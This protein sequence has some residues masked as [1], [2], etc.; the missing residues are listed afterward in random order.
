MFWRIA[1]DTG[2]CAK[3][4]VSN[5]TTNFDAET[6]CVPRLMRLLQVESAAPPTRPMEATG[7]ETKGETGPETQTIKPSKTEPPL[8]EWVP[9]KLESR[10]VS[11][12][13]TST[14]VVYGGIQAKV[15]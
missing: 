11:H 1:R 14:S 5:V 8:I 9:T 2:Q 15:H 12:G 3:L 6:V 4:R 7:P 10:E 13:R